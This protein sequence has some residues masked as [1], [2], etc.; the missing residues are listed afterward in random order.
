MG[1]VLLTVAGAVL[2]AVA[3][4]D[5]FD[6]LFHPHGRGV[7]SEAAVRGIWH[8]MRRVAQGRPGLLSVA[9][10]L[11][12]GVVVISWVVLVVV[13]FALITLP[14]LPD[15]FVFAPGVD[16]TTSSD[17]VGALYVSLVN[18]TSL[19][20][21]DIVASSDAM[22]LLGPL[23]AAI[24]LGIL[25]ASISWVLSIYG[26][27][28]D[29]RSASHEIALLVEA[30]QSEGA[31]LDSVAP[32]AAAPILDSLAERLVSA[33]RDLLHFPIAYY[34][35]TRDERYSLADWL[36]PLLAI[37]VRCEAA[38]RPAELRLHATRTRLA[39][40]D[41]LE[42]LDDEYLGGRGLTPE[43]TIALFRADQL[44]PGATPT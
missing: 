7:V 18:L 30:E 16:A 22:R 1:D 13:G 11:A 6:T 33:R 43:R 2:I 37:L 17:L 15:E 36:G 14:R 26:A 19:G 12:F 10:P 9:G 40:S 20:F 35:C 44:R 39:L 3:V 28:G 29:Y 21:G 42:T 5:V 32:A 4:R 27:L 23:E 41:L 25:T 8:L 34:F 38:G 31:A 24:G